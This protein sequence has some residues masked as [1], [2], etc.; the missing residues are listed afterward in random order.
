VTIIPP[1][2]PPSNGAEQYLVIDTTTGVSDWENGQLY[3]GPVAG[4]VNEFATI[5]T[6][7]LNIIS[8]Q[9]NNFI[10]SGS[11]TDAIDVNHDRGRSGTNVID[12]GAGSNF[13]VGSV[14]ALND[15][16]VDARNLTADVFSTAV[17]LKQGDSVTVWDVDQTNSQML[18]TDNTGAAGYT[19]LDI[20]FLSPGHPNANVVL[21]GYSS[22][23]LSNGRL[24]VSFGTTATVSSL[25][26][27]E[28]MLVTAAPGTFPAHFNRWLAGD[29]AAPDQ[30][31]TGHRAE[32]FLGVP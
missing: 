22:A 26:G 20:G 18:T 17:N 23:D 3:V 31:G 7:S 29:L 16:F 19:G 25:L 10:H 15:F 13:L 4:V 32:P 8:T 12:G 24:S 1:P 28:Y 6:D 27:S 11:G 14:T 2:P 30:F 9:L 5:T 21:A